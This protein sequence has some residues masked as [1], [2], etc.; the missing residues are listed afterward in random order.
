MHNFAGQR[1][2]R[3]R[4]A[5]ST[6]PGVFIWTL[7]RFRDNTLAKTFFGRTFIRTYYAVSPTIVK[8]FGHTEW[9]KRMWQGTLDRFVRKLNLEGVENTPYEDH[10]W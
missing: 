3:V 6:A 4:S 1:A 7:R 9:F 8:W 10:A 5:C 2:Q